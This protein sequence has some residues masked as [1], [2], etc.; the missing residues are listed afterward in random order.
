MFD[1]VKAGRLAYGAAGTSSSVPTATGT[2]T[3][4]PMNLPRSPYTISVSAV[5]TGTSIGSGVAVWQVSNDYVA[6]NA[7]GSAT[8]LSTNAGT[9][10]SANAAALSINPATAAYAYGRAIVSGTGT[11]NAVAWFAS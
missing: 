6:W 8:A 9:A 1:H 11:S 4:N 2:N 10:T 7:L 5:T 3:S